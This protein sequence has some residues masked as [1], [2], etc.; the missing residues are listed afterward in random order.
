MCSRLLSMCIHCFLTVD[1]GY[2][3]GELASER[4]DVTSLGQI[5]SCSPSSH[6]SFSLSLKM[7]H[8]WLQE[9]ETLVSTFDGTRGDITAT[10]REVNRRHSTGTT[11]VTDA[12]VQIRLKQ[13]VGEWLPH[14]ST[15]LS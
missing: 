1:D 11:K 4:A 12:W 14:R 2:E 9:D 13:L 7:T 6:L 8:G 10:T 3:S 5:D 15:S